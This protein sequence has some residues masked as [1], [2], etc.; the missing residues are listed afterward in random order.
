[1]IGSQT[2][3]DFFGKDK[4]INGPNS[5]MFRSFNHVSSPPSGFGK[6][7]KFQNAERDKDIVSEVID[8]IKLENDQTIIYESRNGRFY[9]DQPQRETLDSKLPNTLKHNNAK[10]L[11]PKS[12][13]NSAEAS[14]YPKTNITTNPRTRRC[15]V[16]T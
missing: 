11:I 16:G 3:K 15:N 14:F 6:V 8:R 9:K 5:E 2:G 13:L 12:P 7:Q 10:P 1:M 4:S